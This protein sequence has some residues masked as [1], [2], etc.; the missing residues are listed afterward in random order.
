MLQSYNSLTIG[1]LLSGPPCKGG[2]KAKAVCLYAGGCPGPAKL[3]WYSSLYF[4]VLHLLLLRTLWM[5]AAPTLFWSIFYAKAFTC[6]EWDDLGCMQLPTWS[7]ALIALLPCA[8][9]SYCQWCTSYTPLSLTAVKY[10]NTCIRFGYATL[11]LW[12]CKQLFFIGM[13]VHKTLYPPGPLLYYS[14]M[15]YCTFKIGPI[16]KIL[17]LGAKASSEKQHKN[18]KV[19]LIWRFSVKWYKLLWSQV[20]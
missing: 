14:S 2:I 18:K 8:P 3:C 19:W 15:C 17:W 12:I 13:F 1:H 4:L 10:C 11:N 20:S 7:L 6:F 5:R 16:F 9:I